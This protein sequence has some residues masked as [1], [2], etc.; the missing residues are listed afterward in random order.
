[1]LTHARSLTV[2]CNY[3]EGQTS[4]DW[5]LKCLLLVYCPNYCAFRVKRVKLCTMVEL[6]ALINIG[7]GAY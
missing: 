1:M 3:T 4:F 2:A 7:Y 6:Y 5:L